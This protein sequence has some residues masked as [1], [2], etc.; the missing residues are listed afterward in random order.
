MNLASTLRRL[1]EPLQFFKIDRVI[2]KPE[3]VSSAHYQYSDGRSVTIEK[4]Q[5]SLRDPEAYIYL[6]HFFGFAAGHYFSSSTAG[7][8]TLVHYPGFKLQS[9][10]YVYLPHA[11]QTICGVLHKDEQGRTFISRWFVCTPQFQTFV[12]L[13]RNPQTKTEAL[14]QAL[15]TRPDLKRPTDPDLLRQTR[16]EPFRNQEDAGVHWCDVYRALANLLVFEQPIP[17]DCY[18][19]T[20]YAEEARMALTRIA[21]TFWLDGLDNK[22]DL[23]QNLQEFFKNGFSPIFFKGQ[24]EEL[25]PVVP[26]EF[27]TT[28]QEFIAT[29]EFD[30]HPLAA[31]CFHPF[32]EEIEK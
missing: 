25:I 16:R 23:K 32:V 27:K 14:D 31:R 1:W 21:Q 24:L 29:C 3:H 13:I 19:P 4:D 28:W 10:S 6:R 18:V 12:N 5:V 20:P 8:M 9:S 26:E 17:A 2:A 15:L 7:T 22:P 30:A 11:G